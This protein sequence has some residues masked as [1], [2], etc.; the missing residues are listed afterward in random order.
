MNMNDLYSFPIDEYKEYTDQWSQS[1]SQD[2]FYSF[3][4]MEKIEFMQVFGT[5]AYFEVKR[6]IEDMKAKS[7]KINETPQETVKKTDAVK[8]IITTPK[9]ESKNLK[10]RFLTSS[11]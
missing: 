8:E 7:V 2:Q 5:K 3:N 1:S 11:R 10:L 9:E 4:I 6:R